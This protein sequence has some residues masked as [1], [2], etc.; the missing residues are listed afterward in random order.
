MLRHMPLDRIELQVAHATGR[1]QYNER[2]VRSKCTQPLRKQV[3]S[4]I[5]ATPVHKLTNPL[6]RIPRSSPEPSSYFTTIEIYG[7]IDIVN[8]YMPVFKVIMK[9]GVISYETKSFLK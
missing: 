7:I 5:K 8:E 2:A 9:L 3:F 1:V 4:R 6:H